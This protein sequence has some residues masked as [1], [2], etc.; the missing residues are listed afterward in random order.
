MKSAWSLFSLL[1][2]AIVT[3]AQTQLQPREEYRL[4]ASSNTIN[5]SRGQVDSVKLSVHRSKSFK[6]GKASI[7]INEPK[8]RGLKAEI[9][10]LQDRPDEFMLYF[11]PS[12][13]AQVGEYNF[14]PTC[15]LRDKKKGI[16][17]RLIIQ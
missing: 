11:T 6:K 10:Q 7:F 2:W 1:S 8:I 5:L 17:L 9:K 13:D 12:V 15:T 14:I 16:V 3:Q 4:L